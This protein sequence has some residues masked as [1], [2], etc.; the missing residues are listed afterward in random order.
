[1]EAINWNAAKVL[2]DLIQALILAAVAIY[3]WWTSRT[4]A[5]TTA[6]ENVHERLNEVDGHV[7]TLRQSLDSRP[8]FTEI[9]A[10]RAELAAINTGMSRISSQME[11]TTALLNR[12]HEYLLTDKGNAR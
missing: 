12:L 9:N 2:F 11:S 4:R 10:L 8:S 3:V 7:T 5:S 6:L 1:M